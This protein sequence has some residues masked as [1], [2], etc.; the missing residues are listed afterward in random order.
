VQVA[1]AGL[2]LKGV[3]IGHDELA[4][5]VDYWVEHVGRHDPI[6]QSFRLPQ[7]PRGC[8]LFASSNWPVD[9]GCSLEAIVITMR[10]IIQL[11]ATKGHT[12]GI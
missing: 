5:T 12:V 8:H 6:A 3:L 11:G 9:T 2:G 4:Q 10:Y 1:L 7:C